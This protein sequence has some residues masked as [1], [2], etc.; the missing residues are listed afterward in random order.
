MSSAAAAA[1]KKWAREYETI[2]ILRSSI[3]ADEATRIAN[4]V[5]EVVDRLGGK[6]TKVDNWGRR[7]LAYTIAKQTRGIFVYVKYVGFGDVVAEVERNLRLFETVIRYMT[8]VLDG[9]LD[10]ATVTVDPE[11]TKFLPVETA[12][13]EPE[14]DQAS[15]LGLVPFENESRRRRDEDEYSEPVE[16]EQQQQQSAPEGASDEN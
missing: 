6:I 5:A 9:T 12:D 13:E 15:R 4:R 2:Y 16:D 11:E 1:P 14:L 3:D 8:I 7:K 10:I